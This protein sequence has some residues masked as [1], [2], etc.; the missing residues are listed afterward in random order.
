M[1]LC[2]LAAD[3]FIDMF[4]DLCDHVIPQFYLGEILSTSEN[5]VIPMWPHRPERPKDP[6]SGTVTSKV[7]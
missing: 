5:I 7:V 1:T 2:I 6:K 4:S 3:Y